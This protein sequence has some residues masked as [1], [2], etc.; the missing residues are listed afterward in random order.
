MKI[1]R[2][3][4]TVQSKSG[5]PI[6]GLKQASRI[7]T[8]LGVAIEVACLDTPAAVQAEIGDFS[9]PVHAL[10]PGRLGTFSYAPR[11]R[12]WL[13][14][15]V[16]RF[17]AVII[18]GNWQYHGCATSRACLRH[19][20]PYF[21]YPHGML[22]PWFNEAYPLKKLKK[23]LYWNF[24]EHP[25]LRNAEAVLFTCREECLRARHCFA[26]YEVTEKV[27]GYGTNAP[28]YDMHILRKAPPIGGAPYFL[29]MSRIQEKKGLDLLVE[30]Y[31]RLRVERS[32]LPELLI[33][34]PEQQPEYARDLKNRFPQDGLHWLGEVRGIDKWKL[35]ANAVALVLPS[36]Q[37]NFGIV[38]AEALAVGTPAL[39]SDKV[40][41][42]AEVVQ[43]GAGIAATDDLGGTMALIQ[44]WA[45]LSAI[46]KET[47]A[48]AA[49]NLFKTHFEIRRA[50]GDLIRYIQ[51]RIQ[52]DES[53][54]AR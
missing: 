17:D 41:I 34:G 43:H 51:D 37:E 49:K 10:G 19:A 7:M 36:H 40:N 28:D 25:V 22:D 46:E 16:H 3:I 26:P 33:A 39:V 50:T 4:H 18:H 12:D 2:V 27:I 5:G 29:F 42:H 44:R 6:E 13:D 38:V 47:M 35:L 54:P 11:M 21:I 8:E 24:G 32:G 15:N 48:S 53:T 20:V 9:W 23:R 45:Q 1:L 52:P 14:A 31:A 30:A